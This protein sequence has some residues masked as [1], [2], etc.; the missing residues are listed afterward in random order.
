MALSFDPRLVPTVPQPHLPAVP[1]AALEIAAL[2]ERFA[3]PPVWEPEIRVEP[4]FF[5]REPREAAVLVPVV[6]HH[7]A[8]TLLLTQRT[9]HLHDH[10]GQISF[11]GG[12]RD[13]QD[14]SLIHTALRETHEEIGL[15]AEHIDVIGQL[16]VYTTG[17]AYHVTPVVALVRPGFRLKLDE[18][19]VAEAFEVPLA[20]L[21]NP[22]NHRMHEVQLASGRRNF[23]SMPYENNAD[24][25][26]FIW[27][28]TAAMLRNLYRFLS[29]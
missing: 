19:E 2:R 15:A 9:D 11:P 13:P 4:N 16:P 18:F 5:S 3:N 23:Y 8:P 20:F 21:M 29:A 7:G 22:T 25:P 27:G 26:Y 1:D 14:E 12:R 28:A 17:T 24:K 6:Q 10:A